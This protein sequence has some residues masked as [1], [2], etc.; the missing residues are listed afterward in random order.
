MKITN[1]IV[2]TYRAWLGQT[3]DHVDASIS[4]L[5]GL[6]VVLNHNE[7]V[8]DRLRLQDAERYL[9]KV[10]GLSRPQSKRLVA[11]GITHAD[12]QIID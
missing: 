2:S 12:I 3:L 11:F 8:Y 1:H 7:S 10:H 4:V 6:R 9:R 5:D